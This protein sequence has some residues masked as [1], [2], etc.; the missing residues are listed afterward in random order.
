M[1]ETLKNLYLKE[2]VFWPNQIRAKPIGRKTNFMKM[3]IFNSV[4]LGM[5]STEL[6]SYWLGVKQKTGGTSPPEILSTRLALVRVLEYEGAFTFI[7]EDEVRRLPVGV[8]ILMRI[9][10]EPAQSDQKI[11]GMIQ[12]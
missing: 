9:N 7:D 5:N 8:K 10:F 2:R 11:E 6:K 3:K 1:L 4:V 12:R